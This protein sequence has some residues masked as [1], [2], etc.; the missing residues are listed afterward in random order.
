MNAKFNKKS[1]T[2]TV[3]LTVTGVRDDG[4]HL[5]DAEMVTLDLVDR[6]QWRHP[7]LRLLL[8]SPAVQALHLV[9]RQFPV[10]RVP[11]VTD[12]AP[13]MTPRH[14]D[15]STWRDKHFR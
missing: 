14:T 13:A 3:S 6:L 10:L 1:R 2:L 7:S 8:G 15:W 9:G 11:S 12:A 5:I 4:Y